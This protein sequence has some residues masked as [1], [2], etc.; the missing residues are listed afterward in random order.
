[1]S[2]RR[3]DRSRVQI[4]AAQFSEVW[5]NFFGLKRFAK[6][7]G[8]G[9]FAVRGVF[10]PE[11]LRVAG[12]VTK[13]LHSYFFFFSP[14]FRGSYLLPRFASGHQNNIIQNITMKKTIFVFALVAG[15]TSSAES[16]ETQTIDFTSVNTTP[17]G[18]TTSADNWSYSG[19]GAFVNNN[20]RSYIRTTR[21]D[22][23]DVDFTALL[24]YT[25][26]GSGGSPIAFFGFGKGTPDQNYGEPQGSLYLRNPP[27]GFN[28]GRIDFNINSDTNGISYS[29]TYGEQP[30]PS[31]GSGQHKAQ[32]TK[33]GDSITIAV[34]SSGTGSFVPGF[35][36]IFSMEDD[37]AF[38]DSS[39]SS[40]FFGSQ[41]STT[42]F[43]S[44]TLTVV[45]E[46]STYALLGI[47]A[48]GLL[49]VLRKKKTA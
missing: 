22:F 4:P 14:D 39:N 25:V 21:T 27:S 43:Q 32:I 7:R 44:L 16:A 1:M 37:L 48:M 9:G 33:S 42:T 28:G 20:S 18:L 13:M 17:T 40:I 30:L 12:I 3:G 49:L 31:T 10:A 19:S 34:D 45:P 46:P 8:F 6:M 47:G 5:E 29:T 24:V 38:L 35:S 26:S 2:G 36:E 41:A 23:N 15:L 11:S